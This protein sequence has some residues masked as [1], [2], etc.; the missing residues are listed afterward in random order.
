MQAVILVSGLGSR[1][2]KNIEITPKCLLSVAGKPIIQ[3]INW[4]F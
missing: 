3:Y 4:G 2:I 1:I